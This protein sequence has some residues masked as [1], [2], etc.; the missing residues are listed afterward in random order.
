M[1]TN[2]AELVKVLEDVVKRRKLD[3]QVNFELIEQ[4][5]KLK[6][7]LSTLEIELARL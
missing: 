3:Q 1:H 6:D 2:C 7:Q 5:K 4:N